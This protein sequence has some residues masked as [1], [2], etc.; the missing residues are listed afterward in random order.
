MI[1]VDSWEER[2]G[3]LGKHFT[4]VGHENRLWFTPLF[5]WAVIDVR[6]RETLM[7]IAAK[8]VLELIHSQFWP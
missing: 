6:T 8:A 2:N 1:V 7:T 5:V 4:E 3:W